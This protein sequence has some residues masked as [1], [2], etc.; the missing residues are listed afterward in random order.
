[1]GAGPRRD[2]HRARGSQPGFRRASGR[3][4]SSDVQPCDIG[5]GG[6]VEVGRRVARA[7]GGRRLAPDA[8]RLSLTGNRIPVRRTAARRRVLCEST[9]KNL[10]REA[11]PAARFAVDFGGKRFLTRRRRYPGSSSTAPRNVYPL[12]YHWEQLPR[13]ESK[14]LWHLSATPRHAAAPHRSPLLSAGRR[15]RCPGDDVEEAVS[16]RLGGRVA[17]TRDDE[18]VRSVGRRSRRQKPCGPRVENLYVAS[19]STFVTSSQA[20]STFM[21]MAFAVRLADHLRSVLRRPAVPAP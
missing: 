8:Q 13:S 6:R 15:W 18:D 17:P 19:S 12:Q 9:V 7:D 2:R 21:I 1:M 3:E 10:I 14:V 4:R 11:V 20:N 16:R 5:A